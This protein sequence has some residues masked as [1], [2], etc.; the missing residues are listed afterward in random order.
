MRMSWGIAALALL[1][2]GCGTEAA[3]TGGKPTLVASVVGGRTGAPTPQ[4]PSYRPPPTPEYT[5]VPPTRTPA[6]A[7]AE[8]Q[9]TGLKHLTTPDKS[10][11]PLAGQAQVTFACAYESGSAQET[12]SGPNRQNLPG[13]SRGPN[14]G[15][16]LA[17]GT[18]QYIAKAFG[19][20]DFVIAGPEDY[21][22]TYTQDSWPVRQVVTVLRVR[23]ERLTRPNLLQAR[24]EY[25]KGCSNMWYWFDPRVVRVSVYA[26]WPL[27]F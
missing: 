21:A 20:P 5:V 16:V 27:G 23:R 2:A 4:T 18:F 19:T 8:Q 26:P 11:P 24:N 22:A 9:L 14:N 13:D 3:P 15:D 1:V 17:P 10:F 25:A 6:P 7:G 12:N